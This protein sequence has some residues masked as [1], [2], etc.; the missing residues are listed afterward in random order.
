M[1]RRVCGI[2]CLSKSL[3]ING[4]PLSRLKL[5]VL[6]TVEKILVQHYGSHRYMVKQESPT[7]WEQK[8]AGVSVYLSEK[9]DVVGKN[10]F[11]QFMPKA[12]ADTQNR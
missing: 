7:R 5:I 10:A 8:S 1:R 6:G 9:R 11:D 2:S 12:F 3:M 4:R